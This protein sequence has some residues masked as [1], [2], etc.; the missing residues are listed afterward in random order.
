VVAPDE[1]LAVSPEEGREEG[2]EKRLDVP[3]EAWVDRSE[4]TERWEVIGM[5]EWYDSVEVDV[6]EVSDLGVF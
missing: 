1:V 5:V 3:E 4:G 2:E 6:V